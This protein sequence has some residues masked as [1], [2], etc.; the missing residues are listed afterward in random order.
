MTTIANQFAT[1]DANSDGVLSSEEWEE[2]CRLSNESQRAKGHFVYDD[3]Q[4]RQNIFEAANMV[5]PDENGVSMAAINVIMG[6]SMKKNEELK[7]AA[8]L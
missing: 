7:Q 3:A 8:G 4:H 1:A 2:F 5:M 6:A